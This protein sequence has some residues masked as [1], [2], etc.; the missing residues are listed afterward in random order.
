ML[1]GEF[2]VRE[3]KRGAFQCHVGENGDRIIVP[4]HSEEAQAFVCELVAYLNFFIDEED[5]MFSFSLN[6]VN[7]DLEIKFHEGGC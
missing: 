7:L 6:G 2:I 1:F 5:G 4:E 3:I